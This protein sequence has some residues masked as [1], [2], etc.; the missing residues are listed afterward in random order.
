M[1]TWVEDELTF[2]F[3][4][5]TSNITGCISVRLLENVF[6]PSFSL[7][8][9]QDNLLLCSSDNDVCTPVGIIDENEPPIDPLTLQKINH[10]IF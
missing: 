4:S 1:G 8:Q 6:I 9:F 2:Y 5:M 10:Y 7:C 3:S